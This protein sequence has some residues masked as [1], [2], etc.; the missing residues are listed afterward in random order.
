MST[1]IHFAV[2]TA[3]AAFCMFWYV[4]FLLSFFSKYFLISHVIYSLIHWQARPVLFTFHIIVNFPNFLQSLIYNFITLWLQ[5]TICVIWILFII[6]IPVIWPSIWSVLENFRVCL[7]RMC[8]LMFE[9]VFDR[10]LSVRSDWFIIL[11]TPSIIYLIIFC[12]VIL[13]INKSELLKFPT[14]VFELSILP[15]F[16]SF[17]LMDLGALLLV[18][19]GLWLVCLSERVSSLYNFP[20]CF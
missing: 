20:L 16:V 12:L 15:F 10:C 2:S 9:W 3:W 14:I 19:K 5:N 8:M 11:L 13:S 7:R 4:V 17:C 18:E 1:A 6:M